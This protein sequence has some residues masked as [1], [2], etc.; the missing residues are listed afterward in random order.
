MQ[1]KI[2]KNGSEFSVEPMSHDFFFVK[3][4]KVGISAIVRFLLPLPD[5]CDLS[6]PQIKNAGNVYIA[7]LNDRYKNIWFSYL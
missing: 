4:Q 3:S 7:Q 2:I 1:L 6:S 5:F